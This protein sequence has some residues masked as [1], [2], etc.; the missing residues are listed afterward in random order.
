MKSW[1]GIAA[2]ACFLVAAT[3]SLFGVVLICGLIQEY[4]RTV[5]PTKLALQVAIPVLPVVVVSMI[6]GFLLL[7]RND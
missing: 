2:W 5:A 3:T 7:R 6:I 4:G 1:S